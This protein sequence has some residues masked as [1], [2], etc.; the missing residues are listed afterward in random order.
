MKTKKRIVELDFFRGILILLM[1]LQH[2]AFMYYLFSYTGIW[3]FENQSQVSIKIG[4]FCNDVLF[5]NQYIGYFVFLIWLIFFILAGI[6]FTLSK[7]NL[8]R[9]LLLVTF[10]LIYYLVSFFILNY[11]KYPVIFNFG[12]FIGYA[13]CILIFLILDRFPIFVNIIFSIAFLTASIIL[14]FYD[15]NFSLSP[16]RWF[17]FSQ[18]HNMSNYDQWVIFPYIFTYSIGYLLGK[19]IYREKNSKISFL[20]CK[21]FAPINYLGRYSIYFYIGNII[22]FPVLFLIVTLFINGGLL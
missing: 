10:F 4:E 15:L 5:G 7:H 6:S 13:F 8:R 20:G 3:K 11:T 19:T 12:I 1:L 17:N 14:Y 18:T 16:F 21:I 22:V 2:F 9:F